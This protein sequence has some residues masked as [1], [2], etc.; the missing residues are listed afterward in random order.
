MRF[1]DAETL[2]VGHLKPVV[3]PVKVMT[4]VPATRPAEFVRV[5]RTGG[6]AANRV[7]DQPMLTVQAWGPNADELAR[8]CREAFLSDSARITLVRGVEEVTG[9]YQDPDPATNTD[10]VTF[11]VQL[12]VRAAR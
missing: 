12:Q 1:P 6:A 7:L 3:A 8:K 5:W 2:A 9:P 10:R 11:T 4:K